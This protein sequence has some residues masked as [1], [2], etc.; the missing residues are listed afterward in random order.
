LILL[1][2]QHDKIP[3]VVVN[4]HLE[5]VRQKILSW[6]RPE[7]FDRMQSKFQELIGKSYAGRFFGRSAGAKFTVIRLIGKSAPTI[8]DS[9]SNLSLDSSTALFRQSDNS[10]TRQTLRWQHPLNIYKNCVF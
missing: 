7:E 1:N 8:F 3:F 10:K 2:R 4:F 6:I 9:T 5:K